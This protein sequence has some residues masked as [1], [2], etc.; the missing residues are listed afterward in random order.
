MD[1]E[2]VSDVNNGTISINGS[3][4]AVSLFGNRIL[5]LTVVCFGSS[6]LIVD[7]AFSTILRVVSHVAAARDGHD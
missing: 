3:M 2:E 7:L 5:L 1:I 6:Y 4:N